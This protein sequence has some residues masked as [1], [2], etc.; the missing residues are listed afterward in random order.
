VTG[1]VAE[2]LIQAFIAGLGTCLGAAMVL[3]FGRLKARTLSFLLALASGIMGSVILLDLIPSSLQLG[4]PGSCLVGFLAGLLLITLVDLLISYKDNHH[5]GGKVSFLSTGYLIAI[6]IALHDLPEGLAIAAGFST[7]G[8][9]GPV[10]ALAIGL[11][12]IPE[13]M[14]TAAPLKA[15]GASARRILALNAAV[16]IVTPAGTLLGLLILRAT[17]ALISVL[18]AFAAGAM[19]YIVRDKLIPAS[20]NYGKTFFV[21]GITLGFLLMSAVNLSFE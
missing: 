5:P 13:G 4:G 15:G 19:T 14:A 3:C 2:I 17:D 7:S 1:P 11:H 8:T 20:R 6:G 16:S 9:L 10:I 18:L 21:L 12:N